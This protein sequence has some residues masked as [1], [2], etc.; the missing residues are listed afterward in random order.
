MKTLLKIVAGLIVVVL[1]VVAG[2]YVWA[3][4]AS[5]RKMSQ[6]FQAHTVDFPIPYPLSETEAAAVPEAD[7]ATVAMSQAVE[8]GRHLVT[9]RYVCVECHGQNFGGGTMVDA[10]PIGTL[11]GPNITTGRGS[12]T[13]NYTPADWDRIVRHGI[14]PDGKPAAMPSEDFKL[15]SDQE[16]SDVVAYIR[17]APPVDNEV[18]RPSLGP[19][20]KVLVATGQLPLAVE[21]IGEHNT[22][23]AAVPPETG[24]TPE[25]GKHLAGICTGCHRENFAGGPIVGG[26]PAW[27][28]ARNLTPHADGLSNWT[29]EQFVTTMREGKRPDGTPLQAPMSFVTPYAQRMKD[30]ELQ[31]MWAYLRTLPAQPTNQ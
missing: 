26:D 8:R 11:L 28:A 4:L 12:R 10:F 18:A 19:L 31:A 13:L 15:M 14:L 5:S 7:R 29:Y 17:S 25:F 9:S 3:S 23:H 27:P 16:L 20:G 22:P 2:V 30:V 24:A 21:R 1:V 6:T